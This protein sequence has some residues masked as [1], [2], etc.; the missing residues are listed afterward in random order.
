MIFYVSTIRH[1]ISYLVL[2]IIS[3]VINIKVIM[4]D[5]DY[6]KYI[7]I[8]TLMV[9]CSIVMQYLDLMDVLHPNT[10]HIIVLAHILSQ[11]FCHLI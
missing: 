5:I 4:R 1:K 7:L 3:I 6:K 9:Y 2:L 8:I 11:L 10:V